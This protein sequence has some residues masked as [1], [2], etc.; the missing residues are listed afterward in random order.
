MVVLGKVTGPYGVRGWVRI[1]PFADDPD[2]WARMPAWWLSREA[3]QN[4]QQT[5]LKACRPH[6]ESLVCL[7]EGFEDRTAAE[8]LK[9]M[10]VGAPREALPATQENEYYW[11]DLIGLQAVNTADETLGHVEGLIE[12]GANT[13]LRIVS[14]TGEERLLPFVAQIVLAVEKDKGRIRVDW[15]SDW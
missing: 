9:G 12:T 15:G 10:L 11:A 6:G 13:V 2:I 4:W 8:S 3:P 7:F 5:R 14:P 1:H